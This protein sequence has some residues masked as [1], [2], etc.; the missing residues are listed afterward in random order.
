[1]KWNC[2]ALLLPKQAGQACHQQLTVTVTASR[3]LDPS[4]PRRCCS[5]PLASRPGQ[6]THLRALFQSFQPSLS[7]WAIS[8]RE[9]RWSWAP[10][11]R[12]TCGSCRCPRA[13]S[14]RGPAP[15]ARC[16]GKSSSPCQ[17]KAAHYNVRGCEELW[18]TLLQ[19]YSTRRETNVTGKVRRVWAQALS[20]IFFQ[21]PKH[22]VSKYSFQNCGWE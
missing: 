9:E 22:Y 6:H 2:Q 4:A 5:L 10:E 1:M 13:R 14:W 15:S 21:E 11:C 8:W 16:C 12:Q 3:S 18:T 19:K 7:S 17:G 20:E